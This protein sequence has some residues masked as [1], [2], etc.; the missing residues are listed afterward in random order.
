MRDEFDAIV[1]GS[2]PGG[3]T[4]SRELSRRGK[5]VLLLERAADAPVDGFFS[6]ARAFNAVRVGEKLA[7][8]RAFATGGT[9]AVYFGVADEPPLDVFRN[10]GIDLS[11][12][13]EEAKK[14]LPLTVLPDELLAPQVLRTRAGAS[15]LG[16]P[17]KRNQMLIDLSRCPS[18]FA[19]GARWSARLFVREAVERGATLRSGARV[20]RVLLD[21]GKAIGVE[22]RIGKDEVR[23]AF[24]EW[25]VLAAGGA[26]TPHILRA[27]GMSHA[28]KDGFYI[29]PSFSLYGTVPGLKAK[30]SF[31]ASW[32]AELDGD[33][34]IGDANFDRSFYRLM[35]LGIGRFFRALLHSR[36]IGVGVMV[37]DALRGELRD[38]GRYH[39][40]LS[41]DE[42]AKLDRGGEV[43]R[44]ILARAGARNVYAAPVSGSHVGGTIRIKEH[45][46]DTLQTEYE[47]LHVCDGSVIP[48]TVMIT[49]T[50]TL[51][52]LGKYLADRLA[53]GH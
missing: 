29:H 32:E 9:T 2:G 24:G 30:E 19:A 28:A 43:A 53:P 51:V 33:L 44:Q 17:W 13:L 49:P 22:Y 1:V 15:E 20:T 5:R 39:K 45:L 41:D 6:M 16:L 7:T 14:E 34:C 23:Q 8:A 52:C 25:I 35:M 12:Q 38:D 50:L 42:R 21:G 36:T 26:A 31:V 37:R 48:E 4:V 18:G 11:A 3:A 46:D 10:L 27:S 47:N 40:E